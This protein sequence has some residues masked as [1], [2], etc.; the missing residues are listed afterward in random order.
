MEILQAT[1]IR[2]LAAVLDP[3]LAQGSVPKVTRGSLQPNKRLLSMR[4]VRIWA[5]EVKKVGITHF[6]FVFNIFLS[7]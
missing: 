6:S 7:L 1:F 4:T 5:K 3:T 2:W